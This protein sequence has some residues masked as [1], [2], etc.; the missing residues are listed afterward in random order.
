MYMNGR[1]PMMG[2]RRGPMGSP[3]PMTGFHSMG[4]PVRM[5]HRPMSM[6]RGFGF[7]GLFFLP[8]LM[9]GGW[10]AVAL[11]A[12]ILSMIGTVIG[13]LFSGLTAI[14]N[15]VFSGSGLLTGIVIGLALFFVFRKRNTRTV[16]GTDDEE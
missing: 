1:G 9:F 2:A 16:S 11:L 8:A 14:S 7:G 5:A 6:Q 15:E 12:G 3:R 4:H 13:G 10:M